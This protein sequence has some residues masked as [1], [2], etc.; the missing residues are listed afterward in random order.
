MNNSPR[1]VQVAVAPLD[2]LLTYTVPP[3]ITVPLDL[4][5][6]VKIPLGRRTAFGYI[7]SCSPQGGLSKESLIKLKPIIDYDG[8]YPH[9]LPSQLALFEWVA[10]YYGAPLS[11]VIDVAV[12]PSV[13][14]RYAQY[15]TLRNPTAVP[16]GKI[17]TA[18]LELIKSSQRPYLH[19][20]IIRSIKGAA[21]ALKKLVADNVLHVEE[22][23]L[24]PEQ[25]SGEVPAWAKSDVTLVP[26]QERAR[27]ELIN[28]ITNGTFYPALLH[29]VT[30][31]GKT[32]VYIEA[33]RHALSLGKSALII[34]PEIALTPQLIDR[35]RARI[36]EPIAVLH[37]ALHKRERWEGWRAL[38]DKRA[39]VAL[40]ARSAL[41]APLDS[42]G[43][44]I[45]DEE[46]ESSYKQS[47]GLRYHAR[48]L[49][50]VR[51]HKSQAAV[52]L[53][54]ATP[55]LETYYHAKRGKYAHLHLPIKHADSAPSLFEIVDLS[56]IKTFEMPSR[57][58][59][60]QLHRNLTH[61]LEQREQA[62]V[63][64]N[65]RGFASYFECGT[66]HTVL[67]CPHCAVTLTFHKNS[68]ELLCHYCGLSI[69]KPDRCSTCANTPASEATPTEDQ[70][71][72][73][74]T[75]ILRGAGTERVFEELQELYPTA[76]IERL[77]RDTALDI[78]EYRA[79]LD[80]VR[81]GE[82]DILVGTQMIAKGHDLPGVTLV[83]V[84]DCDIGLHL[85][86][87]RAS[88]RVFQLL[89]QVAGRAGRG[90]KQ[91]RV[92]LQTRTPQHPSLTLTARH[93][94]E[95]FARWELKNRKDLGYPPYAKIIRV[96]VLSEDSSLPHA[97]LSSIARKTTAYASEQKIVISLLGPTPAP[98]EKIRGAWRWHILIKGQ[99]SGDM[100]RILQYLHTLH[101]KTTKVRIM[102]DRDPLELL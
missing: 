95:S 6:R 93:D 92:I 33:V 25:T 81:S 8:D 88:E 46:H 31:S 28:A 82:T 75:Y 56:S 101:I 71:T 77:D 3:E 78:N 62:F 99:T 59:S 26:A 73:R 39:R 57:S 5:Y 94:F 74:G 22:S 16:K 100:H 79:I 47:E 37:S 66:C 14:Q 49:A 11:E 20:E 85:P 42:I 43:I 24:R 45:V 10:E 53:G 72:P 61:A 1:I 87:Y 68:N 35:F 23:E 63:L 76:R 34:V 58:I 102:I 89:T 13:P 41:F 80:R 44:I 64:Y 36:G 97:V 15:Y 54:S 50:I 52:V 2:K 7:T 60:P 21:P 86:D 84:I 98:I 29:G 32:E 27:D 67:R 96:I 51:A 38:L 55:S 12:P 48:D 69:I 91:G 9:F 65:K 18:V 83:G 4:G 30:G 17:Q 19:T 40:G 70:E 90:Q